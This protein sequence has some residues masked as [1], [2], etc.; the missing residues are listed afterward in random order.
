VK[1]RAEGGG[2]GGGDGGGRFIKVFWIH[3]A[4]RVNGARRVR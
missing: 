3:L 4:G 1:R 2:G